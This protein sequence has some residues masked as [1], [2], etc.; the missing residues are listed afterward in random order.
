M[1]KPPSRLVFLP[2]EKKEEENKLMKWIE[3]ATLVVAAFLAALGL[4][5]SPPAVAQNPRG[6]ATG[7]RRRVT[8]IPVNTFT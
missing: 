5:A 8:I 4:A 2:G 6:S 1:P 7:P 3:K